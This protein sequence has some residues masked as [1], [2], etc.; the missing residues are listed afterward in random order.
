MNE[1]NLSREVCIWV[2]VVFAIICMAYPLW[3][4]GPAWFIIPSGIFLALSWV[5][6]ALIPKGSNSGQVD[7]SESL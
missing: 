6:R 2:L 4:K 3:F 7:K 5:A 1:K